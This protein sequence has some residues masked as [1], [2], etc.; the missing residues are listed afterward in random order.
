MKIA[1]S[2]CL[3]GDNVRY[4]GTNKRN[5]ELICLLEGHEII[6]ICP[7]AMVFPIPHLP[8]EIKDGSIMDSDGFDHTERLT[9]ACKECLAQIDGCELVILKSKSPSC[10]YG[11]IYDGSFFETIIKGNGIFAALCE[12]NAYKILT[13]NDLEEIRR[14]LG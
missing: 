10:G 4:D 7:E 9:Q 3:M 1:V 2:A 11:E 14:L 8:I 13:E 5:E 12:K 6:R